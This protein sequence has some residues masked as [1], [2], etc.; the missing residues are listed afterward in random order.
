MEQLICW[1]KDWGYLAVFLGSLVEG[2]SVI[3]T[4][5]SMASLGYLSL[6]KIMIIAFIGTVLADQI[7]YFVGRHYG[8]AL[9]DRF[10]RLR[11]SADRAFRLLNKY[12]VGFII[13]CRF[14]YGIRITSAI[15]I[16]TA[17]IPLKR[18]IPLNIL[19][20]FI[21]TIVSCVGGYLLGDLMKDILENFNQI[22]KYLFIGLGILGALIAGFIAYRKY[23]AKEKIVEVNFPEKTISEHH[24]NIIH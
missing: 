23:R 19:S 3:L 10:P 17:Q 16:G 4:A 24:N 11:K 8:P 7:L 6:Y 21:W 9:F 15:V 18:F 20:G 13:G 2:E 5:S 12:D 22:Q 1:V 14:V